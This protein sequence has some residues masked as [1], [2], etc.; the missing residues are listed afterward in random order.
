MVNVVSMVMKS[1]PDCPVSSLMLSIVT[2]YCG[3]CV[4]TV[5]TCDVVAPTF[6]PGRQ[7]V[8]VTVAIVG[9]RARV[10]IAPLRA[11]H[12]GVDPVPPSILT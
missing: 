4:S 8:P 11:A 7:H 12:G 6:P 3:A 1:L 9:Q 10:V 2:P 5:T